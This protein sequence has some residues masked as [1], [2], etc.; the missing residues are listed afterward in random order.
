MAANY[1][2]QGN[3]AAAVAQCDTAI[4]MAPLR[5][6]AVESCGWVWARAGQ[7]KQAAEALRVLTS[8]SRHRPTDPVEIAKVY[9]SLGDP[10]RALGWLRRAVQERYPPVVYLKTDP[11]LDPLRS[12]PRFQ[13]LLRELKMAP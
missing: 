2:M 1:A 6:D 3:P 12:D 5:D 7:R 13:A 9:Q 8:T 10:D 4:A 11:V